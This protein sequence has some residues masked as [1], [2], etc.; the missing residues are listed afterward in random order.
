MASVR[1]M[2]VGGPSTTGNDGEWILCNECGAQVS[3]LR[4]VRLVWLNAKD[5]PLVVDLRRLSQS[6]Q[7]HRPH[8]EGNRRPFKRGKLACVCGHNLGNIQSNVDT[9]PY[10]KGDE[11]GLLKFASICF[12]DPASP[13]WCLKI[14]SAQLLGKRVFK[15][16]AKKLAYS[17]TSQQV[18]FKNSPA[19]TQA[20]AF[21]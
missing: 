6:V 8:P 21:F 2:P 14:S 9:P 3:E 11:V 1:K 15:G 12:D 4:C 7:M 13:G 16:P 18:I 17:L 20:D 10:H 19:V 5:T